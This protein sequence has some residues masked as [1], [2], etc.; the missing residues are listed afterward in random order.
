MRS[1]GV[2]AVMAAVIFAG[3]YLVVAALTGE[4]GT[5]N[6]VIALVGGLA[7]GMVAGLIGAAVQRS[8][9]R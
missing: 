6:I 4:V 8:R 2:S 3:I 1:V 9:Q 7:F 5:G